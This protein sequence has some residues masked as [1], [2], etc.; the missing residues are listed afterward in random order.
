MNAHGEAPAPD[1]SLSDLSDEE[2]EQIAERL[3]LASALSAR[4]RNADAAFD[5]DLAARII[6]EWNEGR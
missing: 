2:V 1:W 3:D 4:A 6:R 5:F